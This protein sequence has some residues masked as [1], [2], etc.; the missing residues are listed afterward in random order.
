MDADTYDVRID[1][2]CATSIVSPTLAK[3]L[4]G[5]YKNGLT[6]TSLPNILIG[7]MATKFKRIKYTPLGINL[8]VMTSKSE[9]VEHLHEY[10]VVYSYDEIKR[11]R[12][13]VSCD[14]SEKVNQNILKLQTEG[15]V[16]AVVDNFD[17]NISCINGL[18][19]TYD[20]HGEM[21]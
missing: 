17:C 12:P 21:R 5:I 7:N 15:L 20:D 3:I 13:S 1:A 11:F 14:A 18:K 2:L 19:Q 6:D 4:S 9:I 16:Q 10:Q 8:A